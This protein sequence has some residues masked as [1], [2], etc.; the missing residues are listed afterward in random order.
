MFNVT[1][2]SVINGV[3][4]LNFYFNET[5]FQ[6]MIDLPL[7]FNYVL[8]MS[9][10]LATNY[11]YNFLAKYMD[12]KFEPSLGQNACSHRRFKAHIFV[13]CLKQI[14]LLSML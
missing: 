10:L 11:N 8:K 5:S 12:P 2:K 3:I 6:N 4:N 7:F 13:V 1:T 14:H 9:M